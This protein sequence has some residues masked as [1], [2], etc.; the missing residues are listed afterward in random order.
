MEAIAEKVEESAGSG[1]RFVPEPAEFRRARLARRAAPGGLRPLRVAG[2]SDAER[3]GLAV[4]RAAAHQPRFRGPAAPGHLASRS[5]FPAGAR[6]R[7]PPPAPRVAPRPDRPLRDECFRRAEHGALRDARA[8]RRSLPAPSLA[9][10]IEIVID[11]GAA[12]APRRPIRESLILAGERSRVLGRRE[13]CRP[14]A[15]TFTNA[16]TEIALATGA[17]LEHTK[18]QEESLEA[19]HVAHARGAA[20]AAAAGL[21]L[22]QRRARR[23]ARAHRHPAVL[24]GEGAECELYGLFVGRGR[25]APR[26]P[27]RRSTTPRRT[28]PAA[29]STRASWTAHARGVF[30]GH[31]RRPAGRAEDRRRA[32]QQEPAALARGAR[33]LHARAR[34]LRRRR[35]V[36]ARLDHRPARRG[37]ALLPALARHR[38]GRRRAPC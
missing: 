1:P 18:L 27:H 38:R 2:L 17:V 15:A 30:H 35:Q 21:H 7:S 34:D 36:Q 5:R 9:E 24:G 13:L 33:Q 10:P 8:G 14:P 22:A 6:P 11:A 37:G 16:V 26:Q 23:G 29:S 31:D 12:A 20:G 19:C 3:R 25:A 4:H 28:A 32:D